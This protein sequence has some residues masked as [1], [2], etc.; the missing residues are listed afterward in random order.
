MAGPGSGPGNR[1]CRTRLDRDEPVH[2]E[3][4]TSLR[5]GAP[6]RLQDLENGLLYLA[7]GTISRGA[8]LR[9]GLSAR[10][11]STA[12]G[13]FRPPGQPHRLRGVRATRQTAITKLTGAN[14]ELFGVPAS[15]GGTARI[16]HG[17]RPAHRGR[18]R[19]PS[20]ARAPAAFAAPM[21]V[22]HN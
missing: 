8:K 14:R 7:T 15:A 10:A 19:G 2:G 5:K 20:T 1:R 16:D 12:S 4:G 9:I 6:D 3:A 17:D 22:R 11:G 13:I 18:R 21:T